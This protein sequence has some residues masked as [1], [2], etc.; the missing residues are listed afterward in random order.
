M[1][2]PPAM[3]SEKFAVEYLRHKIAQSDNPTEIELLE[4]RLEQLVKNS[5]LI[6]EKLAIS[7]DSRNLKFRRL[8][9]KIATKEK[10]FVGLEAILRADVA[11]K[12]SESDETESLKDRLVSD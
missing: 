7:R 2:L 12:A 1:W 11:L 10:A 5:K 8:Q 4:T 3:D 9:E 6:A